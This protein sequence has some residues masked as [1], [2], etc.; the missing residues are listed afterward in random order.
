MLHSVCM[1]GRDVDWTIFR[2]TTKIILNYLTTVIPTYLKREHLLKLT[3][4]EQRSQAKQK[5][6]RGL[7]QDDCLPT[8]P[9]RPSDRLWVLLCKKQA[10][11]AKSRGAQDQKDDNALFTDGITA[12]NFT[13]ALS[14]W[15]RWINRPIRVKHHTP[16]RTLVT[17][18]AWTSHAFSYINRQLLRL[19][20][21]FT[22]R[23]PVNSLHWEWKWFK[24]VAVN[25]TLFCQINLKTTLA[26]ETWWSAPGREALSMPLTKVTKELAA[27][28]TVE[29]GCLSYECYT[30]PP[31]FY[32]W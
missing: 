13:P 5:Q 18:W 24:R 30:T 3:S 32:R 27:V 12:L 14:E 6:Q 16:S 11:K 31:F 25:L 29:K 8:I 2:E 7:K 10:A 15:L 17:D 19:T 22:N 20:I 4:N 23:P 21:S 26:E 28:A 1:W 9:A